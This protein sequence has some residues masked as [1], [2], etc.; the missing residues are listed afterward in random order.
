[1]R[2]NNL[3]WGHGYRG[4]N[5]DKYAYLQL[6]PSGVICLQ[7][8]LVPILAGLEAVFQIGCDL[9]RVFIGKFVPVFLIYGS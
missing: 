5:E 7:R 3:R 4:W 1:M 8:D 2:E 9:I 6:L